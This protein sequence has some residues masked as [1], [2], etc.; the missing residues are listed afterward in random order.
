MQ[1]L[2]EF[3][4][5][6]WHWG[7]AVRQVQA[8]PQIIGP[9][10]PNDTAVDEAGGIFPSVIRD[11]G[12]YR[13]WYNAWQWGPD[14]KLWISYTVAYAE[15]DD[16]YHWHKPRLGLVE[17]RG[18]RD[19]NLVDLPFGGTT[20][21]VD[22]TAPASHR[23]R[24][25]GTADSATA[26]G[27]QDGWS[28]KQVSYGHYTA[29]SADGFHWHLDDALPRFIPGDTATACWDPWA[30]CA[31]Y[32]FRKN[33]RYGAMWRRDIYTSEGRGGQY[34]PE[35]PALI[36]DDYD[37]IRARTFGAQTCD[38]YYMSWFPQPDQ[39][40]GLVQ[41]EYCNWLH[42][43]Q[44]YSAQGRQ[45]PMHGGPA[46]QHL[47]LAFR[48]RAGGSWRHLPGRPSFLEPTAPGTLFH[49]GYYAAPYV[50]TAADED[51]LFLSNGQCRHSFLPREA[52]LEPERM[53]AYYKENGAM[54]IHL[55]RWPRGRIVGADTTLMDEL[56]LRFDGDEIGEGLELRLNL[57]THRGGAVRVGLFD[58]SLPENAA[59]GT[60]PV[61]GYAKEDCAPLTGD[62]LDAVV[63]WKGGALLPR[64]P[65]DRQLA[66]RLYLDCATVYQFGVRPT[67]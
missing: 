55:A 41:Y 19:N 62:Q 5:H 20:V 50:T 27:R 60:V 4:P 65:V 24:A 6:I 57:R 46:E 25:F 1:Q 51:W 21:F 40:I 33:R 54:L 10:I 37:D 43:G 47:V 36:P 48:E 32:A 16:G 42:E 49:S 12:R 58:T 53:R 67:G 29:H 52:S 45:Y 63:R 34:T 7:A 11:G 2:L 9:V 44:D 56:E 23:Y 3:N 8:R 35:V 17:F 61:P 66:V 28:R 30:G 22:S 18:S 14:N 13:M 26:P 64:V 38:Y 31:R 59:Q 15:S 39:L